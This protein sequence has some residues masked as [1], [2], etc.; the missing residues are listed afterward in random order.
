[1]GLF[2]FGADVTAS[3]NGHY[4]TWGRYDAEHQE[5]LRRIEAIETG[6]RSTRDKLFTLMGFALI[7]LILPLIYTIIITAIH[8]KSS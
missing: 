7:G 1:M 5:V 2:L 8:L 3:G 4:V 6:R